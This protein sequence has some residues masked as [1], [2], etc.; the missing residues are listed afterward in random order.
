MLLLV[1]VAAKGLG[2]TRD[3]VLAALFGASRD[4]DGFFLIFALW[5]QV[6]VTMAGSCVQVFVPRWHAARREG[7][8]G[9][10]APLLGGTLLTFSGLLTVVAVL[11]AISADPV[12]GVIAPEFDPVARAETARLLRLAAPVLPLSG[13]AGV[14]VA[15][16]HA[17]G[18]YL[19]VKAAALGMNVGILAALVIG[20]RSA[21][22]AA[23]AVGCTLGALITLLATVV[24][25]VRHRLRP[26]LSRRGMRTGLLILGGVVALTALGHSGGYL[27]QL[28]TRAAYARLPGGQLTSLA[29][30]T[31]VIGLP[32]Q[33]IQFAVL[34]TLI[35]VLSARVAT[36]ALAEAEELGRT[37]LRVLLVGLLPATLALVLLR[38][39]VVRLLFQRGA[40]SPETTTLTALLLGC[41]APATLCAMVRNV[42]ATAWYA[43]G[44]VWLPNAVGV[45]GVGVFVAGA[46]WASGVAGAWGLALLQGLSSVITLCALAL[47][48]KPVL[49]ISW[50]G[51]WPVVLRIVSA[52]APGLAFVAGIEYFGARAAPADGSWDLAVVTLALVVGA[53]LYLWQAG[54]IGLA[55]ELALLRGA[56]RRKED[57]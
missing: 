1:A 42:I 48:S 38:E 55:P 45:L 39:P 8:Q 3:V 41:L 57:R 10:T 17:R 11:V 2:F 53:S 32:V 54:R 22:L 36:G 18:H 43:R 34:T 40:F 9:G 5:V 4:T 27:M 44:A 14:L 19:Y 37:I 50:Q 7:G 35:G 21:G 6:A 51:V 12:I 24:Y 28:A 56:L 13:A 20:G 46:G 52:S 33:M 31:R 25:P 23:A 30:A 29:Y 15:L 49:G 16:A 47:L 26:S